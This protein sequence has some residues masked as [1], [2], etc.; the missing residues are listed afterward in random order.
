[1][2]SASRAS[3]G[4]PQVDRRFVLRG[5]GALIG[6]AGA[7]ALLAGC[8]SGGLG[9]VPATPIEAASSSLDPYFPGYGAGGFL[10]DHYGL[11]LVYGP[12]LSTLTGTAT[13]QITP[14]AALS[15][16]SLDLRGPLVHSALINGQNVDFTQLPAGKLHLAVPTALSPGR[17]ATLEIGYTARR[18]PVTVPGIGR[19][20]WL[21]ASGSQTGSAEAVTVLSLPTG[22]S[23]WYP[24]VDHPSAKAAYDFTVTAPARFSVLANGRL[25]GKS[26]RGG[27]TS[28]TYH[29]PGPMATYLATIQIGESELVEPGQTQSKPPAGVLIRN[30]YPA[31]LAAAAEYDLGRQGQ[32]LSV[33]SELFGA[34]P[35]DVYG[36]MVVAGLP[37]QGGQGPED[38]V[39]LSFGA[40]TLGLIDATLIDGRRTNENQVANAVARQWFGAG[41]SVADWSQIWLTESF[42]KYAEWLW[43]ERTGS[44]SAQDSALA[45]MAELRQLPQDLVLSDPDAERLLDVRVALRGACYL[46]ALRQVMGDQDFFQLL[47]VWFNRAAAGTGTTADFLQT[48]PQVYTGGD[49]NVLNDSWVYLAALPE[50]P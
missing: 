15:G 28:W 38:P 42:A 41:V 27:Q 47:Q 17:I 8:G 37:G 45:A 19:A 29:H 22:A 35:F 34:Y 50:L 20:G 4:Q 24:C 6:A 30:A 39:R 14:Y 23:T 2:T 13:I 43:A 26:S 36:T 32:M 7:S 33:F 10:V 49:L 48:I 16:L 31:D 21:Q 5:I 44:T 9:G 12:D 18:A 3:A 1:M 11:E 40:Q 46:Q 25:T